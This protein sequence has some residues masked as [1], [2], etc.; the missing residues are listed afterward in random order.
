MCWWPCSRTREPR[1]LFPARAGMTRYDAVN[2]ISHG[3]PK[4]WHSESRPV[5]GEKC[6]MMMPTPLLPAKRWPP[7]ASTS[8]KSPRRTRGPAIGRGNEVNRA[9]Q[10]LCRRNKN[11]PLLVGDP[12]VGKTLLQKVWRVKLSKAMCR[13]FCATILFTRWIWACCWLARAIAVISRNASSKS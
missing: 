7:I 1:G 11:N 10:I 4:T 6:W 9:I 5:V 3:L 2:F 8:M 12:G 13:M